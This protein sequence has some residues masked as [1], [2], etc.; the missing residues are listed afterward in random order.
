MTAKP[1]DPP[2]ANDDSGRRSAVSSPD[3]RWRHSTSAGGSAPSTISSSAAYSMTPAPPKT[4]SS[5]GP[6]KV[7]TATVSSQVHNGSAA[8]RG[9]DVH[10]SAAHTSAALTRPLSSALM[11]NGTGPMRS[12]R[13]NAAANAESTPSM[14]NSVSTTT[15]LRS[16]ADAGGVRSGCCRARRRANRSPIGSCRARSC[17]CCRLGSRSGSIAIPST[18]IEREL[19]ASRPRYPR[20]SPDRRSVSHPRASRSPGLPAART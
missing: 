5:P 10:C 7:S 4:M 19:T 12:G 18:L 14:A 8:S 13:K 6:P 17:Q 2:Q 11:G 20:F 16:V 15:R 9:E 3:V 1:T